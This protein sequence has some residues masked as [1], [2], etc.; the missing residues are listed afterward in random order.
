MYNW[1]RSSIK[2]VKDSF[3]LHS[4]YRGAGELATE[5]AMAPSAK[6]LTLLFL[7][8][9]TPAPEGSI[10]YIMNRRVLQYVDPFHLERT[11]QKLLN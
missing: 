11:Y 7:N 9:P 4:Q 10:D 3:G 5:G 8:I 2:E 6:E 1:N